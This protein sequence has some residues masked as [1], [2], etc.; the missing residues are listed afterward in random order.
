M[1][2]VMP[3]Q[4]PFTEQT[5]V[6]RL[7]Q[8]TPHSSGDPLA[9]DYHCIYVPELELPHLRTLRELTS[10]H[11]AKSGITHGSMDTVPNLGLV[12]FPSITE[13]RLP[14]PEWLSAKSEK[15]Y[16]TALQLGKTVDAKRILGTWVE[17]NER[18]THFVIE[19]S[20]GAYE[21]INAHRLITRSPEL[22][23]QL[24]GLLISFMLGKGRE[25]KTPAIAATIAE[26]CRRG[27]RV[28]PRDTNKTTGS[29]QKTGGQAP[30]TVPA[31]SP[32]DL[33]GI[34]KEREAAI[35]SILPSSASSKD[36]QPLDEQ[37]AHMLAERWKAL[38]TIKHSSAR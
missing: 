17:I 7:H 34:R 16:E 1:P 33:E 5:F 18:T 10:I 14:S 22:L 12:D 25:N 3:E 11:D 35:K 32:Q 31:Y 36:R 8:F 20:N 9:A 21:T 4:S 29:R 38:A 30:G 26:A 6:A 27:L 28:P 2:E 37:A 15:L 19:R 23:E 24:A 13:S